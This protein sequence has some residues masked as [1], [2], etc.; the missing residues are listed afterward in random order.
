MLF[1]WQEDSRLVHAVCPA[2]FP[3][4]AKPADIRELKSA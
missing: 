2:C 1:F 3:E 4:D